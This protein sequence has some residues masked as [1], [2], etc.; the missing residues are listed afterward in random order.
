VGRVCRPDATPAPAA[1][2][3]PA[4]E[5]MKVASSWDVVIAGASF[6]GLAAATQLAGRG[7][8]LLIDRKP[9]GERET[10]A[11]A[12]PLPVLERLGA[13]DAV[14]Q[15]H[16]ELVIHT[17]DARAIS[18]TPAYPFATFDYRK[19]CQILRSR[20][21]AALLLEAVRAREGD[22]VITQKGSLRA[23][24]LIDASG[25]EGVFSQKRPGRAA[26][27]S[28]GIEAR[29]PVAGE[30]LHLWLRPKELS[31]GMAWIFPAGGHSRIGVACYQGHGDLRRRLNAFAPLTEG[32]SLYGGRFPSRLVAATD[33][34]VLR[35][36]DAAGLCLPVTGEGIRPALVFGQ[37][38]G[39]LVRQVLAGEI[40]L[41]QALS[42]YRRQVAR[43]ATYYGFLRLIQGALLRVP[44]PMAPFFIRAIAA[45]FQAA[46]GQ[47]TYWGAADPMTLDPAGAG[48][49][50]MPGIK[51]A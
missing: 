14:E 21:D 20:T 42:A 43:R 31:C 1:P 19:L 36:G 37:I 7:S 39:R 40:E 6:A 12:T 38:A 41:E 24:V 44:T 17:G 48:R 28:L 18:V 9:V 29:A 25:C 5:R 16:A 35:V 51:A 33:G 11:C 22:T 13:L 49:F 23:R 46:P 8:V 47:A 50:D 45:A 34:A 2:V 30:G 26:S 3:A 4:A 10:S 15:I 32:K 27:R